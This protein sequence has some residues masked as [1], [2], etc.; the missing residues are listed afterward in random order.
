MNYVKATLLAALIGLMPTASTAAPGDGVLK[1]KDPEFFKTEEA[2][3]V[4]DQLLIWQRNTGGWPKN[5]DMVTPLND[6]QRALV[7]ADKQVTDDSTIDN[8]ATTMQMTYLARLWQATKDEKYR[9][10]FNNGVRYLLSG[11]YPNGGWPQFWPTMRNYQAHITFNDDAMVN[12]LIVLREILKDREPF[13]NLA[14]KALDK[15]IEKAF[16][17]GIECILNTQIK[18]GDT[19]TVWCQQHDHETLLPAKARAYELPS[20]CSMESVPIVRFLMD[21]PNPDERI[22]KAIHGAMA[23]FDKHKITGY[24]LARIGKKGEPGADTRLVP[25]EKAGPLWARFYDLQNC[26]PYVCD[27][28]G[29]PRKSLQEIGPERRNGYSWYNNRPEQLFEKYEKWKNKWKSFFF[30]QQDVFF[31]SEHLSFSEVRHT[32]SC[33]LRSF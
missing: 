12:T 2:R 8:G 17:K 22:R 29:I 18:H 21:L 1:T 31:S 5:I 9:E 28:D 33:H 19:L 25:D 11:Q 26:Q 30:I 32:G 3:R 16:N 20:Y 23:W 6:E 14:D 24:R 27:R 10:A 15:D 7:I 4:G 13:A